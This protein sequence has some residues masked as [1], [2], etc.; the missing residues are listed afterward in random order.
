MLLN[1]DYVVIPGLGT[2]IVQQMKANR[3]AAEEAFLPPYRSVR[4][5]AELSQNDELLSDSIMEIYH[6]NR[7][8]AGQVLGTWTNEFMQTLEDDGCLDFGA[9]GIFTM[10]S[11]KSI[12]FTPHE[13]GVTTPEYYGL[14]AFHM[15]EVEPTPKAKVVPMTARLETSD[16]EITIRI[17]RNIVNYVVAACAAILLFFV[18]T[19]PVPETETDLRSSARELF[20]PGNFTG[21]IQ[22]AELTA[23]PAPNTNAAPTGT[24]AQPTSPAEEPQ[25]EEQDNYCIV[26]ASAISQQNAERY[27]AKLTERG[28]VSARIHSSGKMIRVVVG[29]YATET[30]AAN[31]AR[32]M[33]AHSDE[34]RSAWVY[35]L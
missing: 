35:K 20:I 3:N 27:A 21:S 26:L 13:S 15:N 33:R 16:K 32:E 31:A 19:A 24:K 10:E 12:A 11:D 23:Q 4:F 25:V 28:F 14:D 8:Q 1:H 18:F 7:E 5:N 34:Y 30:E 6:L 29:R 2:F 17:N 22:P 9:I